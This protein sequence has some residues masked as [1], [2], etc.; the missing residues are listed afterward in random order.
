[1]NERL[2]IGFL[3]S[4]TLVNKLSSWNI[5]NGYMAQVL[6]KLAKA[7]DDAHSASALY[8]MSARV[9][10]H[11]LHDLESAIRHFQQVLRIDSRPPRG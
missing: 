9:Y 5:T 3:P 4:L 8:A 7:Q 11:D 6:E 1:M 10:Q 2:K